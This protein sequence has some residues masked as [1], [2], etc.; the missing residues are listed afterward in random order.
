[1]AGAYAYLI[2]AGYPP[3]YLDGCTLLDID[4]FITQTNEVRKKQGWKPI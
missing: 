1:M 2:D 3:A 4:L